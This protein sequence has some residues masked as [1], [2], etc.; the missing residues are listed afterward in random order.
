MGPGV[1]GRLGGPCE[2]GVTLACGDAADGQLERS[3][4]E[5]RPAFGVGLYHRAFDHC[6]QQ[7]HVD[8]AQVAS[9]DAGNLRLVERPGQQLRRT[10]GKVPQLALAFGGT[11][12]HTQQ[13]WSTRL[14]EYELLNQTKE[15]VR[16]G[17]LDRDPLCEAIE[18]LLIHRECEQGSLR[19][20]TI[21]RGLA[22]AS[23]PR[24]A[25]QGNVSPLTLEELNERLNERGPVVL[26]VASARRTGLGGGISGQGCPLIL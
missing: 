18:P 23:P 26:G 5:P 6:E 11:A 12:K 24:D 2:I 22:N 21:Q 3:N 7:L 9:N 14:F 19:E 1:Y 10:L 20:V 15:G 13:S 4:G 16:V 17:R 8:E 25:V